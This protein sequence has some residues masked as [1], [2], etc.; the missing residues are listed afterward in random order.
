MLYYN[1]CVVDTYIFNNI[2]QVTT[3]TARLSEIVGIADS[4]TA[5]PGHKNHPQHETLPCRLQDG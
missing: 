2:H 3:L 5:S 1:F 4:L